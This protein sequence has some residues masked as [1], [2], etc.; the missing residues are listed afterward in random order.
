M[1]TPEEIPELS[2]QEII[3]DKPSVRTS[4]RNRKQIIRFENN[5][6][7][8]TATLQYH[9]CQKFY[10]NKSKKKFFKA[11]KAEVVEQ[12]SSSE[13]PRLGEHPTIPEKK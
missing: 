13:N 1:Q 7:T 9:Q 3:P 10:N 6:D 5:P 2:E 4:S 12:I 11:Y 8:Y